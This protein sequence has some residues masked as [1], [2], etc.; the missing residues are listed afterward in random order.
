[1]AREIKT[2]MCRYCKYTRT[3]NFDNCPACGRDEIGNKGFESKWVQN[4]E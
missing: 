2:Y 1:M 3:T 4:N